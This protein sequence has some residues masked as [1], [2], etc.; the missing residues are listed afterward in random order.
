MI[1]LEGFLGRFLGLLLKTSLLLM[2]PLTKIKRK[3]KTILARI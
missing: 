1:E 3:K 2:K